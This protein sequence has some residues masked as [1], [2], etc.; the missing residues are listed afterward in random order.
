MSEEEG[1]PRYVLDACAFIAYLNDEEGAERVERLLIDAAEGRASV[2]ASAVN[3]CEVYY[4]CL[5]TKGGEAAAQLMDEVRGLS[6]VIVRHVDDAL[7]KEA[8]RLKVVER[9]SLA[10]AFALALGKLS[11]A[12]VVSTDHHEFDAVAAKGE[13]QLEWLR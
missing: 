4:D 9:V 5:R 10:D 2:F 8:G 12:V 3:V 13:I 6:V 1:P 7:L 11:G